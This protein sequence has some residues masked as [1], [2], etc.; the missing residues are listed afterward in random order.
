MHHPLQ[1]Q[2]NWQDSG[3]IF[4]FPH[5]SN[6]I[7]FSPVAS[8]TGIKP[9][10]P[11][12]FPF[13]YHLKNRT[14]IH[15]RFSVE[16]SVDSSKMMAYLLFW[17]SSMRSVFSAGEM[18]FLINHAHLLLCNFMCSSVLPCPCTITKSLRWSTVRIAQWQVMF[19]AICSATVLTYGH[20]LPRSFPYINLRLAL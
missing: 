2:C 10:N 5:Q 1:N 17:K 19:T 9:I 7:F 8:C 12:Q 18:M 6:R 16:M 13:S 15:K 4:L 20:I 14:D 3:H 11:L